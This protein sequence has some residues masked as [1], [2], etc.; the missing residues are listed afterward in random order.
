MTDET[1]LPLSREG[2]HTLVEQAAARQ[3]PLFSDALVRTALA[4][5]DLRDLIA[6]LTRER[7]EQRARANV[8]NGMWVSAEEENERLTRER[9]AYKAL[10][11]GERERAA[12]DDPA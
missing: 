5:H 3:I 11:E 7:D 2:I 10:A 4:A 9:D 6:T 1:V 8:M 12:P